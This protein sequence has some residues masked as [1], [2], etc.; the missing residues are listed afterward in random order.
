MNDK[1]YLFI[2]DLNNLND[3]DNSENLNED[4]KYNIKTIR[5]KKKIKFIE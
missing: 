5:E 3:F 1:K 2:K 4:K